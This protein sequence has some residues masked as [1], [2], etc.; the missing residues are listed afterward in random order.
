[1]QGPAA[2]GSSFRSAVLPPA[3]PHPAWHAVQVSSEELRVFS[4]TV[5][6]REGGAD[7]RYVTDHVVPSLRPPQVALL[8]L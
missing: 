2:G 8:P 4:A 6:G 1:M 3:A 5:K 7:H